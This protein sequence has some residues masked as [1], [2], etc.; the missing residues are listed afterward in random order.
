MSVLNACVAVCILCVNHSFTSASRNGSQVGLGCRMLFTNFF[1]IE[2][3]AFCTVNRILFSLG[4]FYL[5]V[6]DCIHNKD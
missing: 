1:F 2:V 4:N 6:F 5:S 3:N